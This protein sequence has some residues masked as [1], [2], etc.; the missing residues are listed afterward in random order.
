[1]ERTD[2]AA[3]IQ[4]PYSRPTLAKLSL[5]HQTPQQVR[6]SDKEEVVP[7]PGPD[8]AFDRLAIVDL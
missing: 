8:G 7:E 1:M 2:A 3:D 6:F 5:D 4:R